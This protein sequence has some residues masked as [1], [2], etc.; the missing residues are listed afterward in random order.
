M[1]APEE[2]HG[3]GVRN[4]QCPKVQ[5]ALCREVAPVHVVAE[6]QEARVFGVAGHF[7]QLHQ[8]KVLPVAGAGSGIGIGA[9][10]RYNPTVAGFPKREN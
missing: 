9:G 1:I 4:F 8:V 2:K 7:E 3:G 6:E 5:D 10:T